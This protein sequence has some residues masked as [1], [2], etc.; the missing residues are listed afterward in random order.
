MKNKRLIQVIPGIV[1]VALII[2]VIV[3][4]TGSNPKTSGPPTSGKAT[5]TLSPGQRL[6][7]ETP[8]GG[9]FACA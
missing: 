1:V 8:G 9:G 4:A 5:G 6:R 2:V 3:V 7:I